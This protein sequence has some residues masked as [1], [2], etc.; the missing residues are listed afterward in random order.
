ME[1]ALYSILALYRV[2]H[3]TCSMYVLPRT[4]PSTPSLSTDMGHWVGHER[5]DMTEQRIA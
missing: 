2:R 1:S 5:S 4:L 3:S